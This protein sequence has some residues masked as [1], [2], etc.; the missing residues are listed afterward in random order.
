MSTRTRRSLQAE[1][2]VEVAFAQDMTPQAAA[3]SLAVSPDQRTRVLENCQGL[4]ASISS[5]HTA[6]SLQRR[7]GTSLSCCMLAFPDGSVHANVCTQAGHMVPVLLHSHCCQGLQRHSVAPELPMELCPCLYGTGRLQSFPSSL[8][9]PPNDSPSSSGLYPSRYAGPQ[10][11]HPDF[12]FSLSSG[13]K[14]GPR[15]TSAPGHIRSSIWSWKHI[16][17]CYQ[18]RGRLQLNYK[19]GSS[20][21]A[22][23]VCYTEGY[24]FSISRQDIPER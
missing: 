4:G 7:V 5:D 13:E 18:N 21:E 6:A 12:L 10:D 20:H 3:C 9:R 16:S 24:G 15:G 1:A 19:S 11:S 23:A 17:L 22:L 8:S 14:Q 2:A